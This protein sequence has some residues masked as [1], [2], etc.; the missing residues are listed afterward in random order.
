ME[1]DP[2]IIYSQ[3]CTKFAKDDRVVEVNIFRLE[4]EELWHLEVINENNTSTVLDDPF[5]TDDEA[6]NEFLA[7]VEQE[8]MAAFEDIPTVLH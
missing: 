6:Y 2:N 1:D 3:R 8:G 5:P 7:T 4:T